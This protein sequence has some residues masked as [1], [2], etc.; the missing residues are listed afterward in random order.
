MEL[1]P[2]ARFVLTADVPEPELNLARGAL[3]I[4]RDE[5]PDLEPES[6]LEALAGFAE[7]V[8]D[9]AG[10]DA[11]T[12]D[13]LRAINSCLF[14]EYGL[15]G[16]LESYSD[17]R[18]SYLNDVLERRLGIPISLAV[19]YLDVAWRLG[20]DVAGVSFPGHFLVKCQIGEAVVVIDPFHAGY[21]LDERDL[22][23]RLRGVVGDRDDLDKLLPLCLA[24]ASK[25]DILVRM[26]RNLKLIFMEQERFDRALVAANKIC[27]LAPGLSEEFRDRGRIYEHLECFSAALSDYRRYLGGAPGAPDAMDIKQ[28]SV[29]MEKKASRLN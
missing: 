7:R 25:R 18:N 12:L 5:Y 22:L 27:L 13:L 14:E 8:E 15:S 29:D 19:I 28:R 10:N 11:S 20:L 16:N 3:E 26:L 23:E 24:D 9:V 21:S 1:E 2:A 17:P 4:A 6:V